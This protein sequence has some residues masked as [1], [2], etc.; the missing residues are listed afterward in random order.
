MVQ[1]LG[2]EWKN[3]YRA[4]SLADCNDNGVIS[5]SEFVAICDKVKVSIIPNEAKQLLR[6]F[7][8][9]SE[10]SEEEQINYK[11]LSQQLGL[12]K[13]SFNFLNKV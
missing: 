5:I 10:N 8:D 2:Y 3:I 9:L 4:L 6:Q 1:K 13:E 12:H 11:K 7:G